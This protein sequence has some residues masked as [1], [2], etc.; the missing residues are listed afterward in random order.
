MEI[1]QAVCCF[2][3][4]KLIFKGVWVEVI[5]EKTSMCSSAWEL[6]N[7]AVRI[8][9]MNSFVGYVDSCDFRNGVIYCCLTNKTNHVLSQSLWDM[10]SDMVHDAW[11][12]SWKKQ[13]LGAGYCW[14]KQ[15]WMIFLLHL[16]VFADSSLKFECPGVVLFHFFPCLSSISS[17][18]MRLSLKVLNLGG[19]EWVG[20]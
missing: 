11:G 12:L 8:I 17:L 1:I 13:R 20:S 9:Y 5:R 10:D 18:V 6:N 19:G 16:S 15:C 4:P 7:I 2:Q 3:M 14:G